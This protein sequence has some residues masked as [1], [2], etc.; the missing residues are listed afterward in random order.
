MMGPFHS[1]CLSD[2]C[3][4]HLAHSTPPIGGY[5]NQSLYNK[6]PINR[7]LLYHVPYLQVSFGA[8]DDT[9]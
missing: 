1:D 8:S 5:T 6:I 2:A 3:L 4:K 7:L 9:L